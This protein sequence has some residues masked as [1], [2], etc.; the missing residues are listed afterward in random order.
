MPK[1]CVGFA[2]SRVRWFYGRVAVGGWQWRWYR[3]IKEK[4]AVRMV[5]VRACGWQY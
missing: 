2:V 4:K 5:V 1:M 3:W